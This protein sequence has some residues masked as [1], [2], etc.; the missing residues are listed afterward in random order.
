I[1]YLIAYLYEW[2]IA[3]GG[4]AAFVALLIAGFV[5]MTSVGDP[6]KMKEAMDRIKSALLGLIFLLSSYLILNTINPELTTLRPIDF[7][8]DPDDI[9]LEI[10]LEPAAKLKP[11]DFAI[12]CEGE[13]FDG[14]CERMKPGQDDGF[15]FSGEIGNR[16]SVAFCRKR[17]TCDPTAIDPATDLPKV[18]PAGWEWC[19]VL[20]IYKEPTIFE[21]D[22][23]VDICRDNTTLAGVNY[24]ETTGCRMTIYDGWG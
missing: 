16:G 24:M 18:C 17:R 15:S 6:T 10:V 4:L 3:L 8:I 1:T 20:E 7:I 11:C 2:G 9:H 22:D 19:D 13:N 23:E 14:R 12:V 5:Y 21:D